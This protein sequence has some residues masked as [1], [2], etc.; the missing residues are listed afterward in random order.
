MFVFGNH[1]EKIVKYIVI[2]LTISGIENRLK[3][4]D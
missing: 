4:T 2:A 3:K 1:V